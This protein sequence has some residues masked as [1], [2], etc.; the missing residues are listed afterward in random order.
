METPD[1]KNLKE[2]A[3]TLKLKA[4]TL[5]Q[6]KTLE[7]P[8]ATFSVGDEYDFGLLGLDNYEAAI[9]PQTATQVNAIL[10]ACL[11]SIMEEQG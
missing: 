5:V 9:E 6:V 1:T 7:A 2:E 3:E 4:E 8:R 11:V 10:K